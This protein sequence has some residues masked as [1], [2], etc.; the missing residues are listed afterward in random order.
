M[1]ASK[2]HK[3]N[4]AG[5]TNGKKK[6]NNY[7]KNKRGPIANENT[8]D[9]RFL[10]LAAILLSLLTFIT[11]QGAL[12]NHF[13]DWDDYDYVIQNNLVRAQKDISGPTQM[14][15]TPAFN[16]NGLSEYSTHL[17]DV[18]KRPEHPIIMS[19]PDIRRYFHTPVSV[20]MFSENAIM[21]TLVTC[22]VKITPGCTCDYN[23]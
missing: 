10:M 3:Q 4:K 18:F 23:L 19:S 13:V 9:S 16:P 12:D 1:G 2:K 22:N 17:K 7:Q 15:N 8:S 20:P 5:K 21:P 6:P 11:Y 14:K